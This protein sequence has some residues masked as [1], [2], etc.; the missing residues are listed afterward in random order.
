LIGAPLIFLALLLVPAPSGLSDAGW[1]SLAV[2]VLMALLWISEAIPLSATALLPLVLL[3]LLGVAGVDVAARPYAHPLIFL[4][5]G[6][7]LLARAMQR[8]NLHRRIAFTIV[9]FMGTS[10]SGIIAGFMGA[11]ALL[12]MWV[13]NTATTMMMLPIAISVVGLAAPSAGE[14]DDGRSEQVQVLGRALLL[15]VAYA[16]SIGGMGTLIGTPPNAL[17]AAYL[18]ETHGIEIGFAQWM[19]VGVPLVLVALP[20]TWWLLTRVI[21]GSRLPSLGDARAVVDRELG[22]LGRISFAEKAVAGVFSIVVIL[23]IIRPAISAWIPGL[24]DTVIA[25][26]G[27]LILFA[28]PVN[29]RAGEFVLSWREAESLPW[30][31]LVLFGGGLSLADA[32]QSSGL[33]AW[34]G[35]GTAGLAGLPLIVVMFLIALLILM[36]TEFTSNTAT[37]ATFLPIVGSM[38]GGMGLNPGLL[39][40]PAALAASGAFMMPVATPPNAIVFASGY[41]TLPQMARAGVWINALFSILVPLLVLTLGKWILLS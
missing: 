10:A 25:V 30:G 14:S 16:A 27:A 35:A 4:F 6:G 2:M 34:I 9:R 1:R 18:D 17:M 37:A 26:G 5:L 7:F 15:G 20:I 40:M 39:V 28:V 24:S 3:P 41:L 32:V 33:A 13:S 23:W 19:L 29:L 12:S 38:A 36:L 11:T 21:F 31:V 8:W 22:R